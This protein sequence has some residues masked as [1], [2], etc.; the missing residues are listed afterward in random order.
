MTHEMFTIFE[1][2]QRI[3]E[4]KPAPSNVRRVQITK[5]VI[6]FSVISHGDTFAHGLLLTVLE[7]EKMCEFCN[8]NFVYVCVR[9]IVCY[10]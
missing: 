2:K 4:R 10:F 8:S 1:C 7:E 5:F 6:I 3:I 9:M